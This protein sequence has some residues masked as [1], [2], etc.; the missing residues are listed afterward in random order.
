MNNRSEQTKITTFID[1]YFCLFYIFNKK[2][3]ISSKITGGAIIAEI[4]VSKLQ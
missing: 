4:I 3:L 1:R 2:Y